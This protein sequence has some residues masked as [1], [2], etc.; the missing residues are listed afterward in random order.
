MADAPENASL[1]ALIELCARYMSPADLELI[2]SAHAV[3]DEAHRGVLRKSGEPYIEHPLAVARILAELALDAPAI[4]AALLHD[5][6]EDTSLKKEDVEAQFGQTI[7]A[8][9]DGVTKFAAVEAEAPAQDGGAA[10]P[11]PDRKAR[12]QSETV[13]KLFLAMGDDPR[14]ILLKLADRLHNLRTLSSMSPAQRERTARETQEIYA[15]LAGRLGLY[16]VKSELED[17]AFYYLEPDTFTAVATRLK[18]EE[19]KRADWARRMRKRLKRELT[20][21]GIC[22]AVNW[23]MKRPYRAHREA[24]DSGMEIASLHDLIAFRVLVNSKSDCYRAL[25][26]IHHL[27]HPHADRI[28]DYI[29]TPK[30]NGY[31]SFHTAVFALDGRLAQM[32]IRTHRMHRAAQHGVATYWLERAAAGERVTGENP[33]RVAEALGW[34]TQIASWQ[35]ELGLSAAD[36]VATVRG[37]LLEEQIHVF[38]PKGHIRELPEGSTV[39]DLAYQIHT[40]IGDHATGAVVQTTTSQGLLVARTVGINYV[41]RRGDIVRVVTSPDAKPD[42]SWLDMVRTRYARVKIA[43]SLRR[44]DAEGSMSERSR[45]VS[46]RADDGGPLVEPLQHPAGGKARVEL[47]RCCFPCPGDKI[48]GLAGAGRRVIIHRTCCRSLARSA[49]RRRAAGRPDAEPLAASWPQIQPIT[50]RP[51]LLIS[52][53]D[54]KGLMHELSKLAASMNLSVSGSRAKA[55]SSRHRAAIS[56]TLDVPSTTRLDVV[57]RQL[58]TVPGVLTVE[59]DLSKGC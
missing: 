10:P 33:V 45:H 29:A 16:L 34:V 52:G 15:P 7:A 55:V 9:V 50:Y 49:Q 37:D 54:H 56:L 2:R 4:A 23:R 43:R 39:L 5:T 8:I 18:D 22:A 41:L 19:Q 21:Q 1:R 24:L 30:I 31:Q 13:R 42:V 25:R 46:E 59:R 48:V 20:A 12:Q 28:R 44:L 36:F 47:A 58:H 57:L 3:A 26:V 32:H 40:E 17:L 6:V 35:R 11:S 27:W 14:I 51:H 53:Q 38:T